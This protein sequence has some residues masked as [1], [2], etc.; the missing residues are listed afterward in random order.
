LTCKTAKPA[1]KDQKLWD[2]GGLHLFVSRKGSKS[3]RLKY[4][5]AGKEKLLTIGSYPEISLSAAR[6]SRD[7][8]KKLLRAGI[9]PTDARRKQRDAAASEA[10]STF[11]SVARQWHEG[12]KP[13]WK[14]KHATNVLKGLEKDI[15]PKVG[16]TPIRQVTSRSLLEAL[17]AVQNRGAVDRARRLRQ[18]ISDVFSFAIAADLADA[19][20]AAPL[21][22]A[23]KP[24]RHGN[25]RAITKIEDVRALLLASEAAPGHPLTKLAARLMA[26]TAMRSGPLRAAERHEFIG[27]DSDTP[28]WRIPAHKMKLREHQARQGDAYDFTVPLAPAAVEIVQLAMQFTSGGLLFPSSRNPRKPMSDSTLSR[29]YGRLTGFAGRHVPH[30]WRSTF[31]TIMNERAALEGRADDRWIIDKMLAHADKGVEA[32]YNRGVFME[33]RRAIAEAWAELLLN[34]L[35][36]SSSLLNIPRH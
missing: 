31:A 33:R 19:D 2:S 35:P 3:W 34:G 25:Y 11:E 26:L 14:P 18:Q 6:D 30:G 7:D 4:R 1:G 20:P 5:F 24:V 16:T 22:K 10:A 15:F 28:E 36:R 9:D 23:L 32:I 27:L 13:L 8:A 21:A 17:E 12:R 29:M